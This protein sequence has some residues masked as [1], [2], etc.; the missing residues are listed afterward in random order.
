MRTGQHAWQW[1]AAASAAL[2]PGRRPRT[3][4]GCGPPAPASR[5]P[6][7]HPTNAMSDRS[8]PSLHARS[9]RLII[10]MACTLPAKHVMQCRP[11][12]A[13]PTHPGVRPRGGRQRVPAC[14]CAP[15]ASAAACP[16]QT[17]AWRWRRWHQRLTLERP[18]SAL[19]HS[20]TT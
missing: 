12:D 20:I 13:L 16:R 7:P 2:P 18:P 5:R 19:H 1:T 11:Q 9:N 4:S 15:P 6:S 3:P 17:R 14:L 10:D 8:W